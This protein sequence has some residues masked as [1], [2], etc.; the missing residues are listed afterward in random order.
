MPHSVASESG[1]QSYVSQPLGE[2][3]AYSRLWR[4]WRLGSRL[5]KKSRPG[6]S[7]ATLAPLNRLQF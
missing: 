5:I 6:K 2:R 7:E 4:A 1:P 3:K